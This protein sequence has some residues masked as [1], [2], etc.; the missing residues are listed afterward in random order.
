MALLASASLAAG[1]NLL[2]GLEEVPTPVDASVGA[3]AGTEAGP[4]ADGSGDSRAEAL[5]DAG[6]DRTVEAGDDGPGTEAA[7][8]SG[9][10]EAGSDAA[11]EGAPP[12]GGPADGGTSP[13]GGPA[14]EGGTTTLGTGLSNLGPI[15]SD[16]TTVYV[17]Q[18]GAPGAILACPIA[19][20]CP[21]APPVFAAGLDDPTDVV[22]DGTTV[23]WTERGTGD[24]GPSGTVR[25]CPSTGCSPSPATLASSQN[26]PVAIALASGTV[27]WAD[28]GTDGVTVADGA[29][30]K[31]TPPGCTPQQ[32]GT[33]NQAAPS[34]LAVD[35]SGATLYWTNFGVNGSSGSLQRCPT[36]DCP[37]QAL[38]G[39][40]PSA[41]ELV[42]T[43]GSATW[44]QQQTGAEGVKSCPLATCDGGPNTWLNLWFDIGGT[45]QVPT[46]LAIDAQHLYLALAS[47][48]DAGADLPGV[49]AYCPASG[50][51]ASTATPF[52]DQVLRPENLIEVGNR[53]LWTTADGSL[54]TTSIP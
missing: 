35:P 10:L 44:I 37:D 23:Y 47:F 26:H 5:S 40:T 38:L 29:V 28:E 14:P 30:W 45:G 6:E 50:C 19:S 53:L 16:G 1:C 8:E 27:F 18:R 43:A 54:M 52:V 4:G 22:T 39:L 21:G 31:C 3:E 11:S 17:V 12:E 49:L 2:V 36:A 20:G 15:A 13:E 24:A 33:A 32:L 48:S 41:L 51:G 25:G 42:V 7:P 34:S 9:P 46:S